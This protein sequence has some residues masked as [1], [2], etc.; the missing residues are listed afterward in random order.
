MI[1]HLNR[2]SYPRFSLSD[3]TSQLP[4][5]KTHI[6]FM[7]SIHP[8]GIL[9]AAQPGINYIKQPNPSHANRITNKRSSLTSQCPGPASQTEYF[10]VSLLP[11]KL[12]AQTSPQIK[13]S[14]SQRRN[15]EPRYSRRPD[16]PI[17]PSPKSHTIRPPPSQMDGYQECQELLRFA[18]PTPSWY[19]SSYSLPPPLPARRLQTFLSPLKG[20]LE[21]YCLY[22]PFFLA[23]RLLRSAKTLGTLNWTYSRSRSS[24]LSFCISSRSSSLRSNSRSPRLRPKYRQLLY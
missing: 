8:Q 3:T 21:R 17:R 24:W 5:H 23:K 10:V 13:R 16:K 18:W 9:P 11:S 14:Y 22:Q 4:S 6:I 2:S 15:K 20:S 7:Q 1:L 19:Q 12:K